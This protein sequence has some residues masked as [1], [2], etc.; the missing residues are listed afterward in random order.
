M[1]PLGWEL[2]PGLTAQGGSES[3]CLG[4]NRDKAFDLMHK[5]SEL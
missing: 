1:K 2:V 5:L 3:A 4:V